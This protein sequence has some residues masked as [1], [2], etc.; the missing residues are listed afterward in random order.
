MSDDP[1]RILVVEPTK[2]PYVKEIDGSLASMQAI[3]FF[4]LVVFCFAQ[5]QIIVYRAMKISHKLGGV[6]PLIG[7]QCADTEN[8]SEKQAIGFRKLNASDIAFVLNSVIHM[9]PSCSK[10]S[11]NCLI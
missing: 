3:G 4:R 7:D 6:R 10:I 11:I 9:R 1:M 8:L 5:R 2:D